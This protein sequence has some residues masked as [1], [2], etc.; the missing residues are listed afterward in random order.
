MP[1][2]RKQCDV[3]TKALTTLRELMEKRGQQYARGV[4]LTEVFGRLPVYANAHLVTKPAR[5]HLRSGVLVH[6]R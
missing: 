6:A 5:H 4:R 3:T 2:E 1:V